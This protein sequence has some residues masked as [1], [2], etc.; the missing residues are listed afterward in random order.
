NLV[1]RSDIGI[2]A[3]NGSVMVGSDEDWFS[4][5]AKV[6]AKAYNDFDIDLYTED[7]TDSTGNLT[8]D[9]LTNTAVIDVAAGYDVKVT[10]QDGG[11]SGIFTE[12]FNKVMPDEDA[13][14]AITVEN[15]TNVS[16]VDITA[17]Y[18]N[19]EVIANCLDDTSDAYIYAD[20]YNEIDAIDNEPVNAGNTAT[21]DVTAGTD[22]KVMAFDRG[23]A[24]IVAYTD[25]G[26]ANTSAVTVN[27]DGD[28]IVQS[29]YGKLKILRHAYYDIHVQYTDWWGNTKDKWI[30]RS[31]LDLPSWADSIISSTYYPEETSFSPSSASIEAIARHSVDNTAAININAVGGDVKVLSKDGGKAFVEA[32]AEQA[33]NSNTANIQITA[34]AKQIIKQ[35][36]I[37]EGQFEEYIEVVGG[38]VLVHGIGGTHSTEAEDGYT[39]SLASVEA[40][41]QEAGNENTADIKILATAAAGETITEEDQ[42][43]GGTVIETWTEVEGG[44]VKV[45]GVEGGQANI[46][47]LAKN[48]EGGEVVKDKDE[49]PVSGPS[50]TANVKIKAT[51]V[52]V[53]ETREVIPYEPEPYA[54]EPTTANGTLEYSFEEEVYTEGGNIQV[55]A[56]GWGSGPDSE[57][58]I[59]A[60]TVESFSNTS[61][62]FLCAENVEVV[63]GSE[64]KPKGNAKILALAHIGHLNDASVRIN[65]GGYLDVLAYRGEASIESLA[66][67]GH[68]NNAYTLICAD[69]VLVQA[70]KGSKAGIYASADDGKLNTAEIDLISRGDV[71]VVARNNSEA[72][73]KAVAKD[74]S[75]ENNSRV[76]IWA[77]GDV[78]VRSR[79]NGAQAEIQAEAANEEE[80]TDNTAEV[81]VVAGEDIKVTAVNDAK[82]AKIKAKAENGN[83]EN[84]AYLGLWADGDVVVTGYEGGYAE[85]LAEAKGGIVNN[86]DVAVCAEGDVIVAAGFNLDDVSLE[87]I[88]EGTGGSATIKAVAKADSQK[89]WIVE[90]VWDEEAND[91]D[92]GWIETD[93]EVETS[94]TANVKVVSHEGGVAVVDITG[95]SQEPTAKIEA[96]AYD[97]YYNT[98]NVGVAADGELMDGM[99]TVD[100]TLYDAF[101]DL[102]GLDL[103]PDL[104]L[105]VLVAGLGDGS[106]AGIVAYAHGGIENTADTVVC[107]PEIVAVVAYGDDSKAEIKSRAGQRGDDSV[108][109]VNTATTQVY[110][111]DIGVAVED[112]KSRGIIAHVGGLGQGNSPRVDY[113]FVMTTDGELDLTVDNSGVEGDDSATLILKDYSKA[114]D[115]PT[116]DPRPEPPACPTCDED[117]PIGPLPT[118]VAP[119]GVAPIPALDE[120]D[121]GPGGCP[122]LMAWL[123]NEVGVAIDV[124]VFLANAFVSSTDCQP[125]ETA[126]RLKRAATVLGDEDGAR[127]AAMNQVFNE[128][129]PANA[130]FTPAMAASI[131]TAFAGRVNDGTQYASAI[132]YIDAFVQYIAILNT[133]MGSPVADSVAYVMQK[134]GSDVSGS[135]NANMAAFLAARMESGETFTQ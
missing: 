67:M 96:E 56:L 15:I 101:Y 108:V 1:N 47:A 23:D 80:G 112:G 9:G 4:A 17:I 50:N 74:G 18:G 82:E 98:A 94:A 5:I 86:A 107:A 79:R 59:K 77:D 61:D 22:V 75:L 46:L 122:A 71:K 28:V 111:G 72:E 130:P 129:A 102:T 126:A 26:V 120:I 110:A 127:M 48:A 109:A 32:I 91:G 99:L 39:P 100:S 6:G 52:E 34:T 73:I 131:A 90:E 38:D 16:D 29:E 84:D 132:E 41:A 104:G 13:D 117:Q 55:K 21:V 115:C 30:K 69:D 65:A 27:A 135:D 3:A 53:T 97:A 76:G 92:G 70:F 37:G 62:I 19:V 24:R 12:A 116:C 123:A 125:C 36:E 81:T 49:L 106:E 31:T 128:L 78:I 45:I 8:L 35:R 40:V 119:L 58:S 44:D 25:S 51:G 87:G 105:G 7:E 33:D 134:Y 60:V 88:P 54:G 11:E 10:A 68:T 57:A 43:E 83:N 89:E 93:V 14:G 42:T 64:N 95:E 124:Q 114:V 63:G 66:M 85:V 113:P 133:D 118:P 20:A 103:N 121:F 2:K